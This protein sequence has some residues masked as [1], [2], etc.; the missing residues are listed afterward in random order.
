MVCV[1]VRTES[2]WEG[3]N[4]ERNAFMCTATARACEVSRS[5]FILG[6]SVRSFKA[7]L[8]LNP[9]KTPILYDFLNYKPKLRVA[10]RKLKN[11]CFMRKIMRAYLGNG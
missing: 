2:A 10:M 6:R 11:G 8:A 5:E 9:I 4:K 7:K 1:V 3:M